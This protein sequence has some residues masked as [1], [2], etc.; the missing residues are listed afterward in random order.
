MSETA[1]N[2][3]YVKDSGPAPEWPVVSRPQTVEVAVVG[4]GITGLSAALA[5]A[6]S[7]VSVAVLEA[8]T[9]GW[10][11][12][13][14][15]GGQLNPGFKYDPSWFLSRFGAERGQSLVDFGWST[16]DEVADLVQRLGLDCDLRLNGT[17]R[18]AAK[19]ADVPAVRRSFED[20]AAQGMPVDWLEGGA[21]ARLTGHSR[22]PAALL[23]RRGG[24]LNP[25]KYTCG[26]GRAAAQAGAQVFAHA[27]VSRLARENG[28]W[29][30]D[31]NG[32]RLSAQ[33]VM[34]AC[35]GYADKLVPGL[36][37][38]SVPVFSSVLASEPLPPELVR[39]VMPGRQVLYESGLVTVYY[40]VDTA[41]RLIIGG[42]GP[43]RPSS[44]PGQ[45]K[46]IAS[47]A[48]LLW[49]EI[50]KVGWGHAWNGRVSITTDHLPHIHTPEEGLCILYGYN[51][52]GVAMATAMGRHVA[53]LLVGDGQEGDLL[54]PPSE[55]KPIRFHTFWPI[56]VHA[57]VAA[58]RVRQSFRR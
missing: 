3:L 37:R 13:G 35:N 47:Y 10:G 41:N 42:R 8:E 48:K 23:D 51:G 34:V 49:P 22:Y 33:R 2:S 39:E 19:H 28:L 21:L 25:L 16:V 20:M 15:N 14:R 58:A 4:G 45:M 36:K 53:R 11:A 57:T 44:D 26:L 5:L 7:G 31:V 6:E 55:M 32:Q 1:D 24:D 46:A 52:R 30:L 9:P 43:M 29:Q 50:A 18:A 40:R 54:L 56:G 38:L 27:R 12:S 17:L